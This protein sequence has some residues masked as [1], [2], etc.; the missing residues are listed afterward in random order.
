M[1]KEKL[2]ELERI[3]E[4]RKSRVR[5]VVTY[6]AAAFLFGGGA[7][8]IAFFVWTGDRI[9]ALN[10]FNTILPV[11]AAIISYWFAGRSKKPEEG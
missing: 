7:I 2:E 9:N 10:I 5:R 8:F 11:A 6:S 1:D 3:K 4:L